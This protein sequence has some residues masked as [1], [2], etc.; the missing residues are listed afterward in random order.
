MTGT[1][2]SY[3]ILLV[4]DDAAVRCALGDL[5]RSQGHEVTDAGSGAEALA[6]LDSG[7]TPDVVVTDLRMPGMDGRQLM[8]A[9]RERRPGLPVVI[10][11]GS[12]PAPPGRRGDQP[13]P[14]ALL[15][16]P[17][18]LDALAAALRDVVGGRPRPDQPP[19]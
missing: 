2:G 6:C 3:R 15:V 13:E 10:V 5:L 7:A 11:T 12:D 16:K 19:A 18:Q 1:T 4:D 8:R 17:L 9:A 14:D